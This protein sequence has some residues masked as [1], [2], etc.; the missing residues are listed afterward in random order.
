MLLSCSSKMTEMG[1]DTTKRTAAPTEEPALNVRVLG[2][3]LP[4]I[5][6]RQSDE[7]E[8]GNELLVLFQSKATVVLLGFVQRCLWCL[9]CERRACEGRARQGAGWP[10]TS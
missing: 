4:A 9:E 6:R 8:N 2:L 5:E 3:A 1:F 10:A 7:T